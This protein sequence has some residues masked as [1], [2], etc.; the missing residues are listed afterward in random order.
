MVRQRMIRDMRMP[1]LAKTQHHYVRTV[2][3]LPVP[4]SIPETATVENYEYQLH[5]VD[6]GTS[7]ASL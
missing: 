6:H 2:S 1:S 4:R 5:L 3:N 7:P